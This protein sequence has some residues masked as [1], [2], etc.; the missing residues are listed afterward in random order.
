MANNF[1]NH[2]GLIIVGVDEETD[3]AMCDVQMTQIEKNTRYCCIFAREKFAGGIR[4][5]AYVQP[6][7]FEKKI[8][9][10]HNRSTRGSR[11]SL[12]TEFANRIMEFIYF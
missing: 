12:K 3:D 4:P 2:E 1:S 5:T 8:L 10:D 11:T 9:L 7:T 6:L